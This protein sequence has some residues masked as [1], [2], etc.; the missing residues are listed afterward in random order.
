MT[1]TVAL[2]VPVAVTTTT[3]TT[4][5]ATVLMALMALMR[6]R[7]RRVPPQDISALAL[8]PALREVEIDLAP[9]PPARIGRRSA[10]QPGWPSNPAA[11]RWGF[12]PAAGGGIGGKLAELGPLAACGF[13]ER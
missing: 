5:T 10:L 6:R 7:R 1:L 4:M 13:L 9:P 8:L 12:P 11:P 3:T 2:P